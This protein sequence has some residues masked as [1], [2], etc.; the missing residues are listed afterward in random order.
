MEDVSVA[1]GAV[2]T[3]KLLEK[4]KEKKYNLGDR[5]IF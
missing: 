5:T 4:K 3:S 2:H 1:L